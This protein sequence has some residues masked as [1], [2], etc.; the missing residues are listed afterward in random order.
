[1]LGLR[2]LQK[3]DFPTFMG[4][5]LVIDTI[6]LTVPLPGNS[7][8]WPLTALRCCPTLQLPR[9]NLQID[10]FNLWTVFSKKFAVR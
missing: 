2:M 5:S 4:N 1:M 3:A 10:F 8:R 7:L 9:R 6:N